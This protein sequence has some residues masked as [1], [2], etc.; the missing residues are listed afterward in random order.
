M[1][2][3]NLIVMISFQPTIYQMP[4]MFNGAAA[5][6]QPLLFDTAKVRHVS[7]FVLSST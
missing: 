5:F 2:N 3:Q 1:R 7:V 4:L 6:N